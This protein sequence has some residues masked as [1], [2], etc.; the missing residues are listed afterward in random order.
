MVS[1]DAGV[2]LAFFRNESSAADLRALLDEQRVTVH[3]LVLLDL[4]LRL[5]VPERT[6]ILSDVERLVATEIEPPDV[7]SAFIEERGLA[8]YQVD[9]VAAHLLASAVRHGDRLWA[10]DRDL[11]AAAIELD[12]A[13]Q[14]NGR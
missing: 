4:R 6:Q 5:R 9:V 3:P 2:W 11:R 12:V 1:A 7:V 14:L 10:S 8:K 13:Y